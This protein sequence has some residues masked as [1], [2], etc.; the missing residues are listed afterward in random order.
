MGMS[1][2]WRPTDPTA[3]KWVDGGNSFCVAMERAFGLPCT[4]TDKHIEK[5]KGM[6]A[7]GHEGAETLIGAIYDHGSIEVDSG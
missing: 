1:I 4:L 2:G 7:C 5:L 3:R 6:S